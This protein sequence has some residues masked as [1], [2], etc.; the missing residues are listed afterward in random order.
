MT[1]APSADIQE[2]VDDAEPSPLP[3]LKPGKPSAAELAALDPQWRVRYLLLAPHRLG[4]T[5]AMVVLLASSLW[6]VLVQVD[7]VSVTVALPY[8]VSPTLV[9]AAAMGLGFMPLF[10]AGFLFTAVPKWL[11]IEAMNARLLVAPLGMQALGWLL[12]LTGTHIHLGCVLAGLALVWSGLARLTWL[13]WRMIWRSREDDRMHAR[14]VGWACLWGCVCVG[15][16][17][18]ALVVDEGQIA[19]AWVLSALWGFV[20]VVFVSVAHRLIPFFTSSAMPLIEAPYA[21]WALGV[22]LAA[23][24]F[25]V[26]AVW[27]D[28]P[29]PF[30][31]R[32]WWTL[33]RGVVEALAG[34]VLLWLAARWARSHGLKN[35]MLMMLHVGFL[36]LGLALMLG[37]I[38][39]LLGWLQSAPVLSLGALHA[40][41]MGCLGSLMLAMVTRISCAHSGRAAQADATVW[42]LFWVLQLAAMARIAA[43]V[44]G[45][46]AFVLLL[47]TALLWCG[48]MLT[49]G[50]RLLPWYGRVRPDGRPD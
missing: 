10:F 13:Y 26:A 8:K 3:R 30:E 48:I 36:W 34:A 29:T 50:A 18:M 46:W 45:N 4:F 17:L 21:F 12:W 6:W 28:L 19:L 42:I 41:T 47:P 1:I 31:S 27:V 7:R 32:P 20:T 33:T 40:L 44:Q 2:A 35:R 9:H 16:L 25:E 38:A 11:R 23:A 37:G 15:G 49:W 22:M 43:S 5:L 24:I 14:L 39:Q